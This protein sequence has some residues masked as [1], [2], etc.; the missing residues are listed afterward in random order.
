MSSVKKLA[1]EI[2]RGLEQ[3]LPHLRKTIRRKLPLAIAA[4]LEA[5]TAN[6]IELANKLPL[7]VDR[8]DMREQWL[9]RLL[10]N[11]L[12][13]S[14]E[15]MEPL[16]KRVLTSACTHG[17]VIE[18]SMDQTDLGDQFAILMI[19]VRVGDRALPLCWRVE[20]GAAN[21]GFEG[22]YPLTRP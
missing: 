18:L 7:D 4:M 11:S 12:L 1:E 2:E 10:S 15:I 16:A 13:R 3:A 20:A 8:S 17:Q 6:T 22:G 21:I 9:R 5:Q 14:V 19:S